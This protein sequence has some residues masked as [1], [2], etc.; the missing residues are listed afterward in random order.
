MAARDPATGSAFTDLAIVPQQTLYLARSQ[1]TA[2]I[3]PT[4]D[5]A[6]SWSHQRGGATP[7]YRGRA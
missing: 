5:G 2:G 3:P 7:R 1:E 6:W 4:W